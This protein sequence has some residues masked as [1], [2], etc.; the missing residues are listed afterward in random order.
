MWLQRGGR[1]ILSAVMGM[2][3]CVMPVLAEGDESA[4]ERGRIALTSTGYLP[5]AWSD[6]AYARVGRLWGDGAPDADREPE[7]FAAAFRQ[8]YGLHAAPFPNDGL[9]MGLRRA[10]GPNGSKTG[11]QI[12]CLVCHGGSI[13]GQ[14]YVGLGNTTLD[15]QSLLAD[16]SRGEGRLPFAWG[17]NLNTTRGLNNA[18]QVAALLISFR[19]PDLSRRVLPLPLGA[20]LPEMDTPAW[21][22]LGRKAT[23]YYDGRT[24]S[25]SA[26]SLM[27]FLLGDL[28]L[29]EIQSLEPTFKD[30]LAYLKSLKPPAYPFAIDRTR[31]ERG[32]AVFADHCTKCHGTYGPG[33]TYPNRIVELKVIGTD[34]ARAHGLSD[35]LVAHYNNTWFG[36]E[37][38]ADET[39]VGYQAPPLDGIWAT[40]PYLHNGSV[41]TLMALLESSTRPARYLRPRSTDFDHYD[42]LNVGWKVEP[43][44]EPPAP[45][46]PVHEARWY[47]DTSRFGLSNA[48]H[49]FGDSL[50]TSE[51][52][53]L[54]EYLKTL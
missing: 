36:E 50:S 30:I 25:H 33:G 24:D 44:P 7:A 31:A 43:A 39:M 34:P 13:G 6:Q 23:M 11:L 21:W 15:L 10:N 17:F 49:T 26:R 37:Y 27:Q 42:K 35:R 12:D 8:R 38:P 40:A 5:P 54:V 41:P 29:A 45:S 51:R 32:K 16:L 4:A 47:F 9:P 52:R 2:L 48:G 18:G 3:A 19:N 20:R 1:S 14:S 28:S 53:D 22:L 46:T